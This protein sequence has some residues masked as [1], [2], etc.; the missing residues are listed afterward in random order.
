MTPT[1]M[2][3][4]MLSFQSRGKSITQQVQLIGIDERDASPGE[5]FQQ[6]PAASGQSPA[7]EFR[8]PRRRLRRPRSP[9]RARSS[10]TGRRWPSRAG[11]HRAPP[12]MR[13]PEQLTAAATLARDPGDR[14][15]PAIR[16]RSIP[17]RRPA[18]RRNRA[19]ARTSSIRPRSS[20]TGA[21]DGHRP[22]A[23][24]ATRTATTVS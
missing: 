19:G 7:T 18:G 15:R 13:A 8:A 14:D 24:I 16:R 3:P 5:R 4:A 9:G 10:A 23:A 1:V 20:I 11:T 17:I 21:G 6:V 22:D 2:V 12:G